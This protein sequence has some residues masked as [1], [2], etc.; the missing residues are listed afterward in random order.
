MTMQEHRP[1]DLSDRLDELAHA[2][3]HAAD[4]RWTV[5][6][7]ARVVAELEAAADACLGGTEG[8]ALV[9]LQRRFGRVHARLLAGAGGLRADDVLAHVRALT[10]PAAAE[11]GVEPELAPPRRGVT[12]LA[13]RPS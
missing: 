13:G 2:A 11:R 12:E 4:D 10:E 8:E 3:A 7:L 5:A 1:V 6:V 9:V